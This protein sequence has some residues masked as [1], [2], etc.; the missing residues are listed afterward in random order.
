MTQIPM[1]T[2]GPDDAPL[3]LVL[4]HGAGAGMDTPFMG[5]VAEGLARAGWRVVRFEFPYMT[6]AREAGR[7]RPPDGR[8]RL[9]A[10][11]R[12]VI[13]SLEGPE[14]LVLGG[15][16]MG[17]RMASLVAMEADAAGLLV[18]G[19]PF[20]PPGK[21]DQPRIEHLS[22]L[23]CP[24][25]I[26]QGER[27]SFGRPEEVAGYGLPP[28]VAVDWMPDGDHSFKPRKRSGRTEAGNLALAVERAAAFLDRLAGG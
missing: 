6:R 16:S 8:A 11:W 19:Y 10:C 2:T 7:R 14:R 1:L 26:I 28:G 4:A 24:A 5:T 13:E 23:R 15:K 12:E 17:G 27:D 3:T 9:L 21:P 20:H 22:A 25:L 18:L